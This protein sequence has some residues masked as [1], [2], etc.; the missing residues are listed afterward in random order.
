MGKDAI[1]IVFAGGG[2]GGHVYP[3]LAV[4]DKL[5]SRHE[6]FEALFIGTKA[7]LES[8][9]VPESGYPIRFIT[10]RG[11]RGRGLAGKIRTIAGMGVGV[12]QASIILSGFKPCMV[13]GS[14]GY[15]SA[16]VVLAAWL[17]RRPVVLQEQNSIPGLTNRFLSPCASRIYLGF[18]KAA[19]YL[20]KKSATVV[21][22]N[23]LRESI[24][25]RQETDPR[26]SFGLEAGKPVLLVFGGS[27]GASQLNKAAAEYLLENE[28]IQGI[29]QTG[30]KD[31]KKVKEQLAPAGRRIYVSDYI[32]NI[33]SAYQAADV[34]LARS[35]ALSVSELMAVALPS[36]LVPYPWSADD[37]QVFNAQV[38]VEAGGALMLSDEEV[39]G[40]TLG[41]ALHF[42]LDQPGRLESMREGL[43]SIYR[44]DSAGKIADDIERLLGVGP[45]KESPGAG[46]DR[47]GGGRPEAM[48]GV[49][50]VR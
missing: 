36:V 30:K 21:T 8:R 10:S 32:S 44:P 48:R 34:A 33:Y 22:G 25:G 17:Q 11:V 40:R 14:G 45:G 19:A 4:A 20:K 49:D 38:L 27:Q 50:D 26:S 35:G 42:I 13:F 2:T 18:E 37:H 31:F 7:G 3:A 16:A 6:S 23:P 29:V 1:K 5:A 9:V 39:D 28:E 46:V 12:V 47:Q 43:K 41:K 24:T 15:A